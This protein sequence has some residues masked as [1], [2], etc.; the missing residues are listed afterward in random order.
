VDDGS[1]TNSAVVTIEVVPG[2]TCPMLES[3][4]TV[5]PEAIIAGEAVTFSVC[6]VDEFDRPLTYVW[7]FGD[8][9]VEG[10][11][12]AISHTYTM[13]GFYTVD[14]TITNEDGWS[15]THE[16]VVGV[17]EPVLEPETPAEF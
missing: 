1:L 4:M 14:V 2:M 16:K 12:A 13:P 15:V 6:A 3:P 11:S 10:G 7:N 9:V 8:G 5:A 17:M